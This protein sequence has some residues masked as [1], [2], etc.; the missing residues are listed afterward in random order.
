[1]SMAGEDSVVESVRL[2]N[3]WAPVEELAGLV[4]ESVRGKSG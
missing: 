1:M 4:R 3:A 2:D